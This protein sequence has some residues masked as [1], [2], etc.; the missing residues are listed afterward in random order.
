MLAAV[1]RTMC[2]S[3]AC[4]IRATVGYVSGTMGANTERESDGRYITV[5][6]RKWRATNPN[7]PEQ[8]RSEL[9]AELMDARRRVHLDRA[10]DAAVQRARRRVND[11]KM[12]LGERGDP[13]WSVRSDDSV[14]CHIEAT[15]RSL[16][17][18]RGQQKTIC[19]SDVA[20]VVASPSW[21]PVMSIVREVG[22][23]LH[24][25]AVIEVTQRGERVSDARAVVGPIRFRSGPG[26]DDAAP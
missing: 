25:Q 26:L 24:D 14:R 16:L 13:W 2:C 5:D 19:P 18:T 8:L 1:G 20:R 10:D 7:I 3:W 21:R 6:G 22:A 4:L 17:R 15:I 9:V 23:E 11:A 12:A